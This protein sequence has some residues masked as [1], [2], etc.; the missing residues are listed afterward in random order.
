MQFLEFLCVHCVWLHD[1]GGMHRLPPPPTASPVQSRHQQHQGLI[2]RQPTV[3]NY[4]P[5]VY[6][7][8]HCLRCVPPAIGRGSAQTGFRWRDY[9][10]RPM[11]IFQPFLGLDRQHSLLLRVGLALWFVFAPNLEFISRSSSRKIIPSY[12]A[13]SYFI[14]INLSTCTHF[15]SV[16]LLWQSLAA[17]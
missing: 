17:L 5:L 12:S 14:R 4:P 15:P 10:D 6:P 8:P 1:M 3:H 16:L 2:P 11:F 7:A 13:S 9:C